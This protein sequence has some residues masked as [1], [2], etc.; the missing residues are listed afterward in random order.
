MREKNKRELEQLYDNPDTLD[1]EE[2]SRLEHEIWRDE[3][4]EKDAAQELHEPAPPSDLLAAA[5][6]AQKQKYW[7]DMLA[8]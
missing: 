6:E 2:I 8:D 3:Q 1:D 7:D 5:L 4:A